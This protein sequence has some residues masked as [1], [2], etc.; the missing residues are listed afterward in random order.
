MRL[1]S[2]SLVGI[3]VAAL[4]GCGPDYSP[5]TYSSAATQQANKVSQGVVI[6]VRQVAISA[7]GTVGAVTGG[8]AG[9]VL[10][11][12]VPGSSISTALGTV[13]GALV[14]TIAGTGI[15]HATADTTGWEYIVRKPNGEIV[16]EPMNGTLSIS[17]TISRSL[18]KNTNLASGQARC[19]N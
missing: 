12:Q 8:A 11:A 9:G 5:N 10:G 17:R 14:G 15:E 4:V 18:P 13:G 16:T 6:G 19:R 3:S 2:T 7:D 1:W